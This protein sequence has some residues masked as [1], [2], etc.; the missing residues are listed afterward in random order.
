[1]D[2]APFAQLEQRPEEAVP[3]VMP[4][5]VLENVLSKF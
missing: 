1:M 2:T 4:E 5:T 3:I